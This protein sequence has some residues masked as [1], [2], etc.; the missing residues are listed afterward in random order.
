MVQSY[1]VLLGVVIRWCDRPRTS[2]SQ[3]NVLTIIMV[4][5]QFRA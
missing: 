5:C 1:I 2:I 3:E 4:K